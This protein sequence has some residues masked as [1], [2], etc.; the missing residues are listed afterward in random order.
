MSAEEKTTAESAQPDNESTSRPEAAPAAT[1][2]PATGDAAVPSEPSAPGLEAKEITPGQPAA[3]SE[4]PA[5]VAA[6]NTPD[7]VETAPETQPAAME[8]SDEAPQGEAEAKEEAATGNETAPEGEE[9][10]P[11][12]EMSFADLNLNG[13]I[14]HGVQSMGYADPTPIQAKAIPAGLAGKDLIGASQTGTGKTAA[15]GLPILSKLMPPNPGAPRALILEPTRELANQVEEALR[16]YARFTN[17]EIFTIY[18]GVGYEEQ[19][20]KL[21]EGIDILV[22][23]PGRLLDHYG[24]K[25]VKLDEVEFLVLDEADRML[26][27]GFMPDVRKIIGACTYEPR[28]TML[29]SATMPPAIEGLAAWAL[30]DPETVAIGSRHSTAS[31]ISHCLYPV[32]SVQRYE[33]LHQLL[34]RTQFNSVLVFTRTK[35]DADFITARLKGEGHSVTV[36][37]SDRSQGERTEALEGFRSGKFEVLVATDIASRGLDVSTVTHVINYNVPEHAEDY[38][39]RIGRTGRAKNE[40]DA[41]TLMT[42]EEVDDVAAIERL[43]GKP[44]ERKKLDN[45]DYKYTQ[46]LE[47]GGKSLIGNQVRVGAHRGGYTARR[48]KKRR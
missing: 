24:R 36:L 29:F 9:E 1:E 42:A 4:T 11:E 5:A 27:M 23:T 43:I 34:E 33:L 31:T 26:D 17:L 13:W 44:I 46:I 28:Q 41:F 25:Q 38:V 35:V 21:N 10:A 40:G 22:A 8:K 20:R 30:K 12:P 6:E 2:T 15:F 37:H 48:K 7:A 3:E 39:H 16:S 18:G 19:K 14:V 47:D 45:F 32:A